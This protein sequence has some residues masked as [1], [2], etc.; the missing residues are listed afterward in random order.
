MKTQ[1]GF[2]SLVVDTYSVWNLVFQSWISI[3]GKYSNIQ[4]KR[5]F[6]RDIWFSLLPEKSCPRFYSD[7]AELDLKYCK[8]VTLRNLGQNDLQVLKIEL[9]NHSCCC[10]IFVN[11]KWNI[12]FYSYLLVQYIKKRKKEEKR[13][14]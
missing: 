5:L 13:N 10:D 8:M 3:K 12:W 2:S 7:L 14:V 11:S 9:S 6:I 4:I 1:G